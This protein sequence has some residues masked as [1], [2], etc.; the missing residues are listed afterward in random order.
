MITF[1]GI[2][3][4]VSDIAKVKMVSTERLWA[5]ALGLGILA[6]SYL[7]LNTINPDLLQFKFDLNF[8]RAVQNS[9]TQ[10]VSGNTTYT[11]SNSSLYSSGGSSGTGLS[12]SGSDEKTIPGCGNFTAGGHL[13]FYPK[14]QDAALAEE[15]AKCAKLCQDLHGALVEVGRHE[16][17]NPEL[18]SITY[19]CQL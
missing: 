8:N 18:Y 16:D 7:I 1:F 4:M 9:S 12:S 14:S 10:N 13:S 2:Q 5:A 17:S 19:Q 3:Y 15:N 6:G 11:G